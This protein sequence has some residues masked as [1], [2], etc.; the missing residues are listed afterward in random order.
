MATSYQDIIDAIDAAILAGVSGPGKLTTRDG[1]TVEYRNL[2]DLKSAR[3]Y[4]AGLLTQQTK[5]GGKRFGLI[6][7]SHG[8]GVL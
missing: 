2:A 8:S 1:R 3:E 6:P 4:Y 5:G 7:M